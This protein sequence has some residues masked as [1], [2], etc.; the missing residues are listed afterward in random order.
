MGELDKPF[1]QDQEERRSSSE[2]PVLVAK[3]G[4]LTGRRW[5]IKSSVTIGREPECDVVIQDRQVSRYHARLSL[6]DSTTL[7]EDLGSKN[8][9]YLDGSRIEDNRILEDGDIIQIA[10][11]QTFAYYASDA[12]M[13]LED[14][15][16]ALSISNSLV[17]EERS[18]R[19]YINGTELT[20]PLSV[21]QFRLLEELYRQPGKVVQ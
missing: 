15:Y 19:V 10:L 11:V 8:G 5:L 3:N 13:P 6:E 21:S 14:K 20:P 4:P 2:Y 16:P 7:L 18:R 12:T 17:L 9:T 1:S